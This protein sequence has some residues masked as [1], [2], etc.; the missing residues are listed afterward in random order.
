MTTT[1]D[2]AA[3]NSYTFNPVIGNA[4]GTANA[5]VTIDKTGTG[6]LTLSTNSPL[7]AA[8]RSMPAR[9]SSTAT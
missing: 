4:D 3:A 5:G 8:R 9:S 7:S 2:I 1:F 6:T